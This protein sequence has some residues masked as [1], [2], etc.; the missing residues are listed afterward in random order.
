M[1]VIW[2]VFFHLSPFSSQNFSR[3]IDFERDSFFTIQ[4]DFDVEAGLL[5]TTVMDPGRR[6][7][8]VATPYPFVSVS[9]RAN[10]G[11]GENVAAGVM[12][13]RSAD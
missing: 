3:T 8:T 9:P 6:P 2:S 1:D 11:N 13:R 12:E 7:V 5:S 4:M 10:A